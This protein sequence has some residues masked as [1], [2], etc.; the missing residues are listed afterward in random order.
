[1]PLP[2]PPKRH[3]EIHLEEKSLASVTTSIVAALLTSVGQLAQSKF[4]LELTPECGVHGDEHAADLA[5]SLAWGD[6]SIG[7]DADHKFSHVGMSNYGYRRS[8][9]AA[10]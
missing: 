9:L 7:L 4:L 10:Y 6:G 1:M 2:L 8:V 5:E 3:S